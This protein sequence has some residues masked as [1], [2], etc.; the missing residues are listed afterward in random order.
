MIQPIHLLTLAVDHQALD[1]CECL[2]GGSLSLGVIL[3]SRCPSQPMSNPSSGSSDRYM[4][5]CYLVAE[6]TYSGPIG[7]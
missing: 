5:F 1:Y 4:W 2:D 6:S 3:G 7:L